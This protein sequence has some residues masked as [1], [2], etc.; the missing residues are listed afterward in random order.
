MRQRS[1]IVAL[2]FFLGAFLCLFNYEPFS[3]VARFIFFLI[4]PALRILK[5]RYNKETQHKPRVS[6]KK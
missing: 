4:F 5:A 2:I 1:F 3:W 6:G